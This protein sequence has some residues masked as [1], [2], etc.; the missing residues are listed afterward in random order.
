MR[1]SCQITNCTGRRRRGPHCALCEGILD[2]LEREVRRESQTSR[3]MYVGRAYDP[4]GRHAQHCV[5]KGLTRLR[6]LLVCNDPYRLC[7]L[8]SAL[9]QRV[10]YFAKLDNRTTRSLG[11]LRT[12]VPNYLY[13]ASE[14]KHGGAERRAAA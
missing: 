11:G 4:A 12:D 6:V 5:W 3:K 2:K 7:S 10:A 13:V 8:E 1:D 14:P 9:I